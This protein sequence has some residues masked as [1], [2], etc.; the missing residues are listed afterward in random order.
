MS[1]TRLKMVTFTFRFR[2]KRDRNA[3]GTQR[4][5]TDGGK[6]DRAPRRWYTGTAGTDEQWSMASGKQE[7]DSGSRQKTEDERRWTIQFELMA[8]GI[9]N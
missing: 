5:R 6:S 2:V 4:N 1:V 9:Y 8:A 3:A 7:V